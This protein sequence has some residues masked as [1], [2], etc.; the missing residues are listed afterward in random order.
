[1]NLKGYDFAAG[2]HLFRVKDKR[3][4]LDAASGALH[5]LD[6]VASFLIGS[7]IKNEGEVDEALAET[8]KIYGLERAEEAYREIED[9]HSEGCLF[10]QDQITE[11]DFEFPGVPKSLCLN[12]AH[13]CNMRCSYCFASGGDFGQKSQ[14]MSKETARRAV[15]LLFRLSKDRKNLEID[16]FGGEPLL[17][18]PVVK[19]TIEYARSMAEK[20]Q[21]QV[22]FTLTTN[23]LNLGAEIR[24]Y[25]KNEG[26]SVILSLDGRPKVHDMVRRLPSGEGSFSS[27]FPNIQEMVKLNPLSYYIRGTYTRANLDFSRDFAYLANLGF[28]HISLEPVIGGGELALKEDHLE[29]VAREYGQLVDAILELRREGKQV[30]F[31]HFNLE[32][33][34]GPCL[35][36]RITGCSAGVE[37]LAVTP[38]GN[39]YPCHQFVGLDDFLMGNVEAGITRPDLT[40]KFRRTNVITKSCRKCWARYY[41]GGGCHALAFRENNDISLPY[42]LACDIH[43]IRLEWALYLTAVEGEVRDKAVLEIS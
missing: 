18:M 23:G 37:Y 5:E 36:K 6:E 22:S 13:I 34:R 25:L 9:A 11:G 28:R 21:K 16:F 43:K 30:D 40:D 32:Q 17:N 35:A 19:D 1:M 41:C 8:S 4:V 24:S 42:K 12:V 14:L 7:L 3:F 20:K 2:V 33:N 26:I 27:V 10:S 29:V 38:E 31:F 15:D 39:I